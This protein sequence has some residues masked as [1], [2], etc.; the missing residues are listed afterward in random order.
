MMANHVIDPYYDWVL[1]DEN[2]SA[3][4]KEKYPNKYVILRDVALDNYPIIGETLQ[5]PEANLVWYT[6]VID[7]MPLPD[8]ADENNSSQL[9]ISDD[10]FSG[11]EGYIIRATSVW[12]DSTTGDEINAIHHVEKISTPTEV[13]GQD[14]SG[15]PITKITDYT[16]SIKQY[17]IWNMKFQKMKVIIV[18]MP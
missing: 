4:I 6:N 2:F 3:M 9:I 5:T 14:V 12:V 13:E 16:S 17:L 8:K 7:F 10:F 18:L 1:S 11:I 15:N